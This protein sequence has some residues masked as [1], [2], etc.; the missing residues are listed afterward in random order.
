MSGAASSGTAFGLDQWELFRQVNFTPHAGQIPI[1]ADRRRFIVA[2]CGRRFGK[3]EVGGHKLLPEAFLTYGMRNELK[4]LR[5]RREFWIVGPNYSDSEKEFRV[6]WNQLAK[7]QVPFDRGSGHNALNGYMHISLWDGAFQVHAKSAAKPESLV[8]EGLSGVIVAEAAK[9]KYRVWTKYVRPT[10][11]DFRG[12][13]FLSSTPEGKNWF[14]D[15]WKQGID[16]N[17]KQWG[18]YRMPAWTNPFVYPHGATDEGVAALRNLLDRRQMVDEDVALRH[19]VDPEVAELMMGM[20]PEAFKQEIAADFTEFVGRVFKDFDEETHIGD[21]EYNPEWETFAAVDYGFTNPNVW[22]LLQVDPFGEYINV[23]GEIYQ[24]GLGPDEF[25][26]EILRR[27]LAPGSLK[28]FFP[29]PA[30]PGD[31]NVLERRLRVKARPGTGGS[32]ANRIDAIRRKLKPKFHD[33]PIG[34]GYPPNRPFLMF[35]RSCTRTINDFLEYRYADTPAGQDRNAPENPM[36][37][38]DHGPEALGR[39][40]AGY[41]GTNELRSTAR[42]T[43]ASIGRRRAA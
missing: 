2:S 20:V 17:F 1:L 9:V 23:L 12:W 36:K 21:L 42:S 4:E 34:E 31:T 14:Y 32:L 13:A 39:F 11:N 37:K 24:P 35:D 43:K 7:L 25:A 5:K 30:S 18:G 27:E 40:F 3:S 10:L 6:L 26:D 22:L 28:A 29:D 8:G 41:Y 16:P 38:D 15:L 19:G 33:K